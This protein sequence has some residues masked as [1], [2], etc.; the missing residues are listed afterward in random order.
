[1]DI[2]LEQAKEMIKI[3]IEIPYEFEVYSGPDGKGTFLFV[4]F[5]DE[6]TNGKAYIKV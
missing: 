6:T 2:S 3:E 5:L 1:M 4:L